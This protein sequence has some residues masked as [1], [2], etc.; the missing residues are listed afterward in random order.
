MVEITPKAPT[1][2]KTLPSWRWLLWASLALLIA[3]ILVYVGLRVYL[4]QLYNEVIDLN[5]RI[6]E[7]A[8]QV[9][10][11]D[12]QTVV[13]FNDSL[14][15][16]KGLFANHTYFSKFFALVNSSTHPRVSY[17]SIQADGAKNN[18]QLQGVTQS[19]SILAKQ[20]VAFRSSPLI[21]GVEVTGITFTTAGLQFILKIEVKP[22][23]F[24]QQK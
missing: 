3:V 11:Q 6:R 7:A 20:I 8:A 24:R 19:Y 17:R 18:I 12:E 9:N 5:N 16:L 10:I 4:S 2:E 15:S 14:N 23:I 21:N 1:L 13:Q 22:D